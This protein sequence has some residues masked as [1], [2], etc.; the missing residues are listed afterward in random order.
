MLPPAS[1]LSLVAGLLA[2]VLIG[3]GCG[4]GFQP[5]SPPLGQTAYTLTSAAFVSEF[6]A[7]AGAAHGKYGNQVI[8]L[9][10][11][12]VAI[13]NDR[14]GQPHFYL[15]GPDPNG[16]ERASC[17]MTLS[18]P[19]GKAGPGQTVTVKGRGDPAAPVARLVDC[20]ILTVTG[21]PVPRLSADQFARWTKDPELVKKRGTQR[22]FV[23]SG[24]ID[25][26]DASKSGLFLK[27]KDEKAKALIHFSPEEYRRLG[28]ASWQPGQKIEVIGT[29]STNPSTGWGWL[30]NCLP[31]D[32]P[33]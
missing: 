8:E 15:E 24:E 10:G 22:Y 21:D 1:R 2:I 20:E 7:N 6:K 18:R 16:L 25:R 29:D 4:G 11:K 31:M 13:G 30:V 33:K 27:V 32:D 9:T 5:A 23:V 26:I 12:L 28:V 17:R 14:E 19:W 3:I